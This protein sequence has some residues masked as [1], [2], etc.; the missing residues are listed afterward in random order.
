MVKTVYRSHT[1]RISEI[2]RQSNVHSQTGKRR[3]KRARGDESKWASSAEAR[4]LEGC[5]PDKFSSVVKL[6]SIGIVDFF[7][8]I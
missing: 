3:D 1:L 2:E 6:K 8:S 5:V 7:A 4:H